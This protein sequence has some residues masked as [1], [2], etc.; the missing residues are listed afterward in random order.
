KLFQNSLSA[1]AG[2]P[3]IV[4][5]IPAEEAWPFQRYHV[6]LFQKVLLHRLLQLAWWHTVPLQKCLLRRALWVGR[7][8]KF[9]HCKAVEKASREAH[10]YLSIAG[11]TM[12]E[13]ACFCG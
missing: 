1:L 9:P 12:Q 6:N 5:P 10:P 11:Q 3:L 2:V 4:P 13:R 8:T 7:R